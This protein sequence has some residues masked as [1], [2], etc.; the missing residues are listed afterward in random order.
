MDLDLRNRLVLVTGSTSGIGKG[1]AKQFLS[2]KAEVIVNGRNEARVEATVRELAEYG[3]VSGV[4]A[5]ITTQEGQKKIIDFVNSTGEIAILVNNAALCSRNDF[6]G[7]EIEDL[8]DTFKLNVFSMVS[9]TKEF[10]PIMMKANFGRIINISSEAALKP[11]AH[12]IPYSMSKAAVLNFTKGIAEIVGKYN[13]TANSILPGPT[14]TDELDELIKKAANEKSQSSDSL[15]EE[16]I[17]RN[18]P[19]SV[20]KRFIKVEEVA[21]AA[22]YLGSKQASAITGSSIRVEGGMLTTI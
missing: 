17:K 12:L 21:G 7:L 15:K 9:L 5:D 13:I 16:M 3:K 8:Q 10:L 18:N 4:A 6:F 22:L 20:I 11:Y 19:T 2:E 14:L 1:I